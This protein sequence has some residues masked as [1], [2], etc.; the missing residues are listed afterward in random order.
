MN[1]RLQ[2]VLAARGIASRREA[3]RMILDGRI[4]VNGETVAEL[5]TRVDPE[6]DR[7]EVDGRPLRSAA[8]PRVLM[9]NKPVGYLSTCK[10]GPRNRPHRARTRFPAT[11]AISPWAALTRT[12]P[13]SFC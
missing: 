11:A 1:E 6:I 2:K 5:G 13:A 10:P 4:A 3:E 7:I 9:L 12:A 8:V